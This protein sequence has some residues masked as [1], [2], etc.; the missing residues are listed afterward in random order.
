MPAA[1]PSP[2]DG[3]FARILLEAERNVAALRYDGGQTWSPDGREIAFVSARGDSEA[4]YVMH[5]ADGRARRLT[6]GASLNPAWSR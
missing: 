3:A 2:R 1:H 4:L 6:P 5:A